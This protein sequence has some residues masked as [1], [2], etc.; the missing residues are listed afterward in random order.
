MIK[1]HVFYLLDIDE[2]PLRALSLKAEWDLEDMDAT[3]NRLELRLPLSGSLDIKTDQKIYFRGRVFDIFELE[4]DKD[5]AETVLVMD[6]LQAR[7]TDANIPNYILKD[8]TL[9]LAM[10]KAL[11]KAPGWTV[12]DVFE[13]N[14]NYNAELKNVS[15][16]F[17]F[18]FLERQSGGRLVFDS[19]KKLVHMVDP[20]SLIADVVFRYAVNMANVKKTQV[21]PQ[22]TVLFPY[23]R[24]GMTIE[25][26][27]GG[28][29]YVEDFSWY[30]GLG[31]T[32][33]EARRRYTK[34]LVW[35]DDRYIY[36]ANL[37]RDAVT[38]LSL[39]SQPQI[40]YKIEKA[41]AEGVELG[42]MAY[43]HDEELGI[44][45]LVAVTRL[46]R[47]SSPGED[48]IELAYIPPSLGATIDNEYSGDTNTGQTGETSFFIEKNQSVFNVTNV[49]APVIT[50]DITVYSATAFE[51]GVTLMIEVTGA[52][53]LEG[54]FEMDGE[55]LPTEIKQTAA[56]GWYTIGLPFIVTGVQE[57]TKTLRFYLTMAT[58]AARVDKERAQFYVKAAGVYGGASNE[59]P[60][61]V[62]IEE[63]EIPPLQTVT[64]GDSVLTFLDLPR[65]FSAIE[66]VQPSAY[67]TPFI[68]ESHFA[69]LDPPSGPPPAVE[70]AAK[71]TR[72]EFAIMAN[73]ASY[74]KRPAQSDV[75]NF[76]DNLHA[77]DEVFKLIT[78]SQQVYVLS[79][80]GTEIVVDTTAK[81][82][83]SDGEM[84]GVT[85]GETDKVFG[86]LISWQSWAGYLRERE[87]YDQFV[88]ATRE[89]FA[90]MADYPAITIKPQQAD[91]D[92][93][94]DTLHAEATIFVLYAINE[95]ELRLYTTDG[96][97]LD[98][99]SATDQI[100]SD[101]Q[102][103]SCSSDG[104]NITEAGGLVVQFSGIDSVIRA[105]QFGRDPV[106]P[107]AKPVPHPVVEGKN[108]I[109]ITD[110]YVVTD[111]N[112]YYYEKSGVNFASSGI[113]T[114]YRKPGGEF[115]TDG[116]AGQDLASK[117]SIIRTSHGVYSSD[118]KTLIIEPTE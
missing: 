105:D 101:G 44:K 96:T 106:A 35:E 28:K 109:E 77:T 80:T 59:K 4:R 21:S 12:G 49:P 68:S 2:T 34:E 110:Y 114:I 93:F 32:L 88:P 90:I 70:P 40:N 30:T 98:F 108:W 50:A 100:Q 24:D 25:A 104:A 13:T 95:T 18:R 10:G 5:A 42:S 66:A 14:L 48:E 87:Y 26:L 46:I 9:P 91:V 72:S 84:R 20:K 63:I 47:S 73:Y 82:V 41:N 65:R 6:E 53:L 15:T 94:I 61:R 17:A 111:V 27:T 85:F 37:Y 97:T 36:N 103:Y 113:W 64:V 22:A 45:V 118:G 31:M 23:G 112:N 102:I 60:D 81:T 71:K 51:M 56:V 52:G 78:F 86:S 19:A 83:S 99:D 69:Y 67:R 116:G 55:R 1:D 117:S 29:K 76:I 7:L 8:D 43:V 79:T 58:G 57:G 75:D 33:T 3:T 62:I 54:Y 115:F 39:L 92:A 107:P 38:R 16:L 89:E 74:T 11:V